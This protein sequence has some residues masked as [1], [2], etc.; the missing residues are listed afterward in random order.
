MVS[1]SFRRGCGGSL[2]GIDGSTFQ[3]VP[4]EK[5]ELPVGGQRLPEA[6]CALRND[7]PE[8]GRRREAGTAQSPAGCAGISIRPPC[9]EV[10]HLYNNMP[11]CQKTRN[12][13]GMENRIAGAKVA[14][15]CHQKN[16]LE[17]LTK[18]ITIGM[19]AQRI[20]RWLFLF[21]LD[22]CIKSFQ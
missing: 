10:P 8:A 19:T 3:T 2:D 5:G 9:A 15:Y 7:V 18:Q 1:R 13:E 22:F 12:S 6:P 16:K 4:Q 11:I 17:I 21:L 20:C 14:H